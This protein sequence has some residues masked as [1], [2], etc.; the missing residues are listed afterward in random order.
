MSDA[1]L[2][3]D[4]SAGASIRSEIDALGRERERAD[5]EADAARRL[6]ELKRKMGK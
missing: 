3:L 5:R 4:D 2:G 1:D 6:D